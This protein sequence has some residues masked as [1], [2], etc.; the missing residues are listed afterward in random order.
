MPAAL[1]KQMFFM[2]VIAVGTV[3]IAGRPDGFRHRVES[4]FLRRSE[5][6]HC[7]VIAVE[8]DRMLD[9]TARLLHVRPPLLFA[10]ADAATVA[11]RP[12]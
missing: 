11:L 5:W 2:Q 10:S 6:L 8:R 3:D 7:G 1:F 9:F 4:A 12:P